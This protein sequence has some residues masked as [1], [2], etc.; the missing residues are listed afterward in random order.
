MHLPLF[1]QGEDKHSSIFDS[2]LIP[3]NPLG[4]SQTNPFT[5]STQE[6]P[7]RHGLEKHSFISEDVKINF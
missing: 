6:P 2:H 5:P 3:K 4:H 7:F 1:W